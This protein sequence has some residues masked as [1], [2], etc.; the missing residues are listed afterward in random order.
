MPAKWGAIRLGNV[1]TKI[2]SGATP[3]GGSGVYLQQGEITLIRSQNVYNEGFR[4]E[5]LVFITPEHAQELAQV[6]VIP[7]DVLLN[8]TGDSVA[9]C[10]QVDKAVLPARV[11]QHVSIIRPDPQKLNARFLRY[12]L[13]SPHTQARL[14]SWAGS[15]GTR[16]ALTKGMIE[17]FEITG[18][19]GVIEQCAIAT[20]LGTLDEKIELNRRMNETLKGI[21]RAI[22]KSWFVDFG[23]VRT[24]SERQ[25]P[26]D[27]NAPFADSFQES[28]LGKI[29]KGWEVTPILGRAKLLSGGT[30]KTNRKDYW[31][32]EILWA[33]AKDVSQ[34]RDAFLLQTERTITKTGLEKSAT[35]LIPK[36]CTVVVA[37]GATTGRMAL[38]GREMAMNQTCY[39]LASSINTPF[40]LHC[41]LQNEIE[42]LVHEAHGSV[43]DTITTSTFASS[44]VVSPPLRLV[45]VFDAEV[46]PLFQRILANTEESLCLAAIRDTLLPKLI[47]GELRLKSEEK[48]VEMV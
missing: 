43:F 45:Q 30:P 5:G 25:Q 4:R 8:I 48:A 41:L 22:F 37:R 11:N 18:P 10:C 7:G 1:C 15:G 28:P 33:S 16:A 2:G 20:V 40:Y 31:N 39:A 3:R 12:C 19:S 35:Q 13:A 38:L 32:G 36:F 46:T 6:E 23:P 26:F 24:N 14:L 47:S 34:C 44:R 27:M 42:R 29:P 9:R 21:A 17:S